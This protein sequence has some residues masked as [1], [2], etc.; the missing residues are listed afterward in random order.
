MTMTTPHRTPHAP[1]GI[2]A[3]IAAALGM[4]ALLAGCTATS[5]PESST[6]PSA[7]SSGTA[8]QT[9]DQWELSYRACVGDKG[10][11]LPAHAG[12]IDFGDRQS[13]FES[14]SSTCIAKIG[15]PPPANADSSTESRSEVQAKMLKIVTCLRAKGYSLDDPA[16]TVV[17]IP[18]DVTQADV[19]A[20]AAR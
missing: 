12:K 16:D 13:A 14:V 1:L 15:N 9:Y 5:A 18:K 10:F 11:D 4:I 3:T 20:C 7:A 6:A 8:A 2:S 19:D 17:N